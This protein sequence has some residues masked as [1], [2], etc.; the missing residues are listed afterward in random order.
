MRQPPN[1]KN[2][3]GERL[4]DDSTE[5]ERRDS[6]RRYLLGELSEEGR[7]QVERQ[8][9]SRD[10]YFEELLIAEEELTDEYVGERL[11]G[12]ALAQFQRRFLTD[13]ELRQDV[14]FAK[15]LRRRAEGHARRHAQRPA[16]ERPPPLLARISSFFRQPAVGLALTAALLLAVCT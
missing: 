6:V 4:P 11:T 1:D 2:L 16:D 9:I 5:R 14:R 10:D 7:E 15:A 12:P 13:T 8:L 3:R